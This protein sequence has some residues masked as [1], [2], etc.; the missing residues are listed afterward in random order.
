[1]AASIATVNHTIL[2]VAV[3][4]DRRS[5]KYLIF[6]LANEEYG[7]DV[8]KVREIMKLQ[9]ITVVPQTPSHVKGVINLRGKV[10]PVIDLRMRCG[11]PDQEYT[12]HTCII[13]I[14]T[15]SPEGE[16]LMGAIVDGVAEVLLLGQ[17]E[18]E[19]TPDFGAGSTTP[20]I[21][22]LAKVK[23]KVKILLDIDR[24]LNSEDLNSFGSHIQ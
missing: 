7:V 24:V 14:R 22:G 8:L 19:D 16:M 18:I 13:V 23:G 6:H 10:I 3:E 15:A 2:P 21:L 5:G 4:S 17:A 20:Y 11:L 12:D 1:M 9:E